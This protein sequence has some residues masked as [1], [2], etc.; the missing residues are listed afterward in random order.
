MPIVASPANDYGWRIRVTKKQWAA[1]VAGLAEEQTWHN[2]KNEV[3][4]ADL[5][6]DAYEH[7]LHVIWA[8]GYRYQKQAQRATLVRHVPSIRVAK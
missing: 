3:R 1:V 8:E 4:R 6:D 7:M 2:F 5:T